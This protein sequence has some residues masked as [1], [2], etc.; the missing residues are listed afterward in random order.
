MS[1]IGVIA[2]KGTADS[3]AEAMRDR[4]APRLRIV[5]RIGEVGPR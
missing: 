4:S 1:E 3:F 2:K 5:G